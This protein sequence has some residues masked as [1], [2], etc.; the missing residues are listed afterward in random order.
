MS[1]RERPNWLPALGLW[2]AMAV[3]AVVLLTACKPGE[4]FSPDPILAAQQQWT[5]GC[6][7][8]DSH[9]QT[10][11]KLYRAGQIPESVADVVDDAVDLYEA[12]CTVDPPDAGAPIQNTIVLA[13]AAKVCPAMA[14]A[15][16]DDWLLTAIDA[17]AC[18]AEGALLAEARAT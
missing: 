15:N 3:I 4:L 18:V 8:A 17:A 7:V 6:K 2:L 9:I 10:V 16:V 11:T 5:A 12:V 13:L 14:P 1:C